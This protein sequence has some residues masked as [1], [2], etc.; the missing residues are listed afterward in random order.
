M[1]E[2]S[3]FFIDSNV[4]LHSIM[5]QDEAK[6]AAAQKLVDRSGQKLFLRT[7]VLNEVCVNLKR[8]A[9]VSEEQLRMIIGS[10]HLNHEVVQIN[11]S[12][13]VKASEIRSHASFS[14]WDSIV[15]ASALSANAQIL[16]SE[17]M[18]DGY[19]LENRL[20]IENPF[21]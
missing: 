7:Q 21:K 4:W 19:V 12:H 13:L 3:R 6:K 9:N 18:Q 17:D 2:T 5:D 10:F 16:F 11:E 8:K 14:F 15:A 1:T 20:R